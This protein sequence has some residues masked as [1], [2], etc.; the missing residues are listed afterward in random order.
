M[1]AW[2]AGGRSNPRHQGCVSGDNIGH[3]KV[4]C[5]D[6]CLATVINI[7]TYEKGTD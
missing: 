2:R 5:E 7:M 4:Q 1:T 3:K 6:G